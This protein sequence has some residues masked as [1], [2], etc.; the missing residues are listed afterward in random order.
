MRLFFAYP[1][2]S[3]NKLYKNLNFLEISSYFVRNNHYTLIIIEIYKFETNNNSNRH[4]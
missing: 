1:I 2:L 4:V 3:L